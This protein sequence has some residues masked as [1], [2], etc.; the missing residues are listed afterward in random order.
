MHLD[1]CARW[2]VPELG[3]DMCLHTTYYITLGSLE[4]INGS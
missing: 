3:L 1:G 2:N 4:G